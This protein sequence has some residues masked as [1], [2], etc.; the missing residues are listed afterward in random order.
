MLLTPKQM[1]AFG[2]L[3]LNRG[4]ANGRQIVPEAWVDASLT[5][6]TVSRRQADRYYGYGWWSRTLAGHDVY[7]AWGYGG[8]FIFVVPTLDMTIV[9]TSSTSPGD[10]RRDHRD[11]VYDLVEQVII[12]RVEAASPAAPPSNLTS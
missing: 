11:S 1:L 7:Y 10:E 5:R 4:R 12:P 8:Q 9:A 6:L 3:Y 2:E